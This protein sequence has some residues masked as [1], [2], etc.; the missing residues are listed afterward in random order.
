M[1]HV[2][3]GETET[4]GYPRLPNR[5]TAELAAG[6]FERGPSGTMNC[7][8]HTAAAQQGRIGCVYDRLD[9]ARRDVRLQR[10]K[11]RR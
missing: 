7:A 1:D 5:A 8:I 3:G 2:F 9:R 10:L 4:W 6:F 11:V